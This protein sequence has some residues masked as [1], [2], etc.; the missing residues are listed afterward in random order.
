MY[1]REW[2]G[3][4]RC[5]RVQ[6]E[7]SLVGRRTEDG[8]KVKTSKINFILKTNFTKKEAKKWSGNDEVN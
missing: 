5:G 7:T 3:R 4:V 2:G 8:P 6:T 1:Q